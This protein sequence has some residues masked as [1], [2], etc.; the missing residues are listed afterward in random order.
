MTQR[1]SFLYFVDKVDSSVTLKYKGLGGAAIRHPIFGHVASAFEL[2]GKDADR[3][4]VGMARAN[5]CP[6]CSDPLL[7]ERDVEKRAI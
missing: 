5:T 4:Q 2:K 1:P 3:A 7:K 6:I